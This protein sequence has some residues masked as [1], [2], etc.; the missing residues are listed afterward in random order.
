MD[1][2]CYICHFKFYGHK[3]LITILRSTENIAL[4][5]GCLI[6]YHLKMP[7]V[8]SET[9][10]HISRDS[11]SI[12]CKEYRK[13]CPRH[14]LAHKKM[15]FLRSL[16]WTPDSEVHW[17]CAALSLNYFCKFCQNFLGVGQNMVTGFCEGYLKPEQTVY[18]V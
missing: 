15:T 6:R 8:S 13:H 7:R 14:R 1:I 16:S 12:S 18:T 17:G 2:C 4:G 10:S 5:I 11:S 3:Q 9:C